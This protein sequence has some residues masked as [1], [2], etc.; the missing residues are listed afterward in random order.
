[1]SKC[2]GSRF[3]YIKWNVNFKLQP[4]ALFIFFAFRKSD[5]L[6]TCLSFEDLPEYKIWWSH[7]KRWNFC[8]QLRRLVIPPSPCSK[9]PSKKI[10]IRT[11]LVGVGLIL[12]FTKLHSS[13][14][15]GLWVFI[16]KV[17]VNFKIQPPTMF[18]FLFS[19]KSGLFNS[20]SSPED[21]SEHNISWSCVDWCKFCI[22]LRSLNVRHFWNCWSQSIRNYRAE[23]IFNGMTLLINFINTVSTNWFKSW[24][25]QTDKQDCDLISLFFPLRTKVD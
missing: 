22:H 16:T 17:N 6:K 10:T 5:L 3:V 9:F 15:N 20:C 24:W 23:V 8:N 14:C 11:E 13:E 25:G 19:R 1:M 7:V 18:V 12:H 4:P 21:L 2:Y